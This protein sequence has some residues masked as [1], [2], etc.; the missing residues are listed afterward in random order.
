[1]NNQDYG[2]TFIPEE[3]DISEPSIDTKK[4]FGFTFIPEEERPS[5]LSEFLKAADIRAARYLQRG[6]ETIA[7]LP[8][9]I[10]QLVRSIGS[11]LPGGEIPAEK[12][13]PLERFV[14]KGLEALPTSQELRAVSA[15]LKPQLEP[16][17]RFEEAEDEF[18]GDVTSLL[19]TRIPA[20][21]SIG[22][23]A[24]GNIG[25]Q[26]VKELGLG[27]GAQ[28]ATKMGL[29]IFAGMFR[30]GGGINT[31]IDNLYSEARGTV[32]KGATFKYPMS[33][34][35]VLEKNLKKGSLTDAKAASLKII[36]EIKAKA[37]KG[38][39]PVEEAVEF[40]RDINRAISKAFA[41]KAKRG[42]LDQV[43][44]THTKALDVYGKENPEWNKYY[45]EAKLAYKGMATSRK[46]KAFI[47]RNVN[48]KNAAH[49]AMLLG[50]EEYIIPG[51]RGLKLGALGALGTLTYMGEIAKRLARNPALRRYYQVVLTAS[52]NENKA[53]LARNLPKLERVAKKEFE[54]NP[55]PFRFEEIEEYED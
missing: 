48:L 19:V 53:M 9:D 13:E 36:D 24:I 21:R 14:R 3:E 38:I 43:K 54:E 1:M 52:L 44:K 35:N 55:L 26:A 41:D 28:D 49:A 39:I 11:I 10:I 4:E 18:V 12:L 46:T 32:P 8:G 45:K 25:K 42:W 47:K 29:M 51:G 7:G 20:I 40:D 5:R 37:P 31:H 2:F 23:A 33:R 34:L 30:K 22:L 17:T 27:E 15:E 50:A 16:K 6:A